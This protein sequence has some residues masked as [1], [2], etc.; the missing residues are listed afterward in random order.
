MS[1][2]RHFQTRI[3]VVRAGQYSY[4]VAF[5]IAA[6]GLSTA[7]AAA[8]IFAFY[9][10]TALPCPDGSEGCTGILLAPT[11]LVTLVA[12]LGMLLIPAT[13]VAF[14]SGLVLSNRTFG[15]FNRIQDF[16][17]ALK[18]GDYSARLKLREKD[19]LLELAELF[20]GLAE[21]LEKKYPKT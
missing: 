1:I 2:K 17:A 19:H 7:V 10:P 16:V 12:S 8:T 3:L 11:G 15:P 18:A 9:S 13:L 6:V 20:N 4:A 21:T 5:A 14:F